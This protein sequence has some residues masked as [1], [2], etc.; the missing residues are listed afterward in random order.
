VR[1]SARE[2]GGCH[3]AASAGR[4]GAGTSAGEGAA[5]AEK[6]EG[7]GGSCR[8]AVAGEREREGG[9]RGCWRREPPQEGGMSLPRRRFPQRWWLD[10]GREMAA[11]GVGRKETLI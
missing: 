10:L 3:R 1:P 6:E 8:V 11:V 7:G 9:G 5:V 2:R 4:R